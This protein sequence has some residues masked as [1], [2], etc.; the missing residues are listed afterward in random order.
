[1][2][3]RAHGLGSKFAVGLAIFIASATLG[4]FG[5]SHDSE[6]ANAQGQ[7]SSGEIA[8]VVPSTPSLR[9]GEGDTVTL[10]VRIYGLQDLQDQ[11]LGSEVTFDWSASDGDLPPATKG[12]TSVRYT[13]PSTPGTYTVTATA[14][15]NCARNCTATFTITVR[16]SGEPGGPGGTDAVNPPGVI[17]TILTDSEGAQYEVFTPEGGGTFAGEHFSITAGIG[18]VPNGEIIGVRMAE[19]GSA[20]NAGMSHHRFAL[21]GSQYKISVVDADRTTVSSYTLSGTVEVCIPVLDE[22]RSNISSIALVTKN[23]DGTLTALSSSVRVNPSLIVCGNTSILPAVVASGLPGTPPP[24]PEP[25]PEP[26]EKLPV[27][28]GA[29]PS[30]TSAVVWAL[31]LGI[32]LIGAGVFVTA[33]RRRRYEGNR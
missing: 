17:P 3:L 12:S 13:A 2:K 23:S 21:S 10:S 28:G 32:A 8:D 15:S 11:R 24:L 22:L 4:I 27:T 9:V 25:E 7:S 1:M 20:S 5:M 26:P 30:S 18:I 16:R 6:I 14:G 31:L 29:A 19:D 33:Y